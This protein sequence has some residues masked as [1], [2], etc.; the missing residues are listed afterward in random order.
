MSKERLTVTVD[1]ELVRAGTDAVSEG[2]VDSLSAWVNL[3]LADRAV[4]DRQLRALAE[5]V[6]DYEQEF[7][8]ITV[9]ELAAQARADRAAAHIVR[10]PL[11]RAPHGRRARRRG[12]A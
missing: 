3:A 2:R 10:G 9:A 12:A 5:A 4:K 7:G 11:R 1:P 6:A 8:E